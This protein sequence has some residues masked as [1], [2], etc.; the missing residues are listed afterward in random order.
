[1]RKNIF[2]VF[3][4][5]CASIVT[6]LMMDQEKRKRFLSR[7]HDFMVGIK[8]KKNEGFPIDAAGDPALDN[9]DNADM[10]SEGSQFGVQ[11]YNKVKK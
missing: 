7:F 10:V 3:V 11:Y 9:L 4:A 1:M 2:F 5:I 8:L 6:Y